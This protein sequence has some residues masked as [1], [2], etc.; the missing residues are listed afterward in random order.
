MATGFWPRAV[1]VRLP[2]A[3]GL[4]NSATRRCSC[5][6]H[7]FGALKRRRRR[8][9]RLQRKRG[10]KRQCDPGRERSDSEGG[11]GGSDGDPG[12]CLSRR[13]DGVERELKHGGRGGASQRSLNGGGAEA[14]RPLRAGGGAALGAGG[15]FCL[16]GGMSGTISTRSGWAEGIRFAASPIGTPPRHETGQLWKRRLDINIRGSP[17]SDR[18]ARTDHATTSCRAP[19][20]EREGTH[21]QSKDGESMTTAA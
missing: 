7:E 3:G 19:S 9:P 11:D 2:A 20:I 6:A 10:G 14:E 16:S 13:R 5:P 4:Q 21:L 17:E 18:G 1:G 15:G 8:Q 12:G